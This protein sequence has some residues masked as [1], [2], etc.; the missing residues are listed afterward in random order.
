MESLVVSSVQI[1]QH[2][3]VLTGG[4]PQ[5]LAQLLPRGFPTALHP[6]EPVAKVGQ[7]RRPGWGVGQPGGVGWGGC[8]EAG[9]ALLVQEAPEAAGLSGEGNV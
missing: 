1:L 5:R 4:R 8:R 6:T 9:Q 3:A 7:G 2:R